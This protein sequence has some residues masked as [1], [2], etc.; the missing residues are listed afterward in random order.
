MTGRTVVAVDLGAESGRV[1]TVSFDG[2]RFELDVVSRFANTPSHRQGLLRWDIDDL[3][4]HIS[5]GIGGLAGN[6]TPIDAIGVDTWGVDY[7]LLNADG[8]L[9]DAPVSYRDGRNIPPFEDAL[10]ALGADRLYGATGVQLM[11]I[12][13]LF[14]LMADARQ[15]PERLAAAKTLLM[16]PDVFHH[17]L[18]GSLVSE[19]T[20]VST[21]GAYDM[22]A[23][24][25]ATE[26]LDELG[27]PTHMLPEVAAPGTDV[28]P[29][30]GDLATGALA[31]ARVV[32]PPGHDTA[33]A[34]VG[35]PLT[36]P[37]GLYIS[38]GTW[39]LAGVETPAPVITELSKAVNLT[40]EG[41]YAGTI[42]LLR[43]VMGLWILQECR[44]QW[45]REGTAYTYPELA[46]LAAR[47]PGLVSVINPDDQVF[48]QPGDMPARIREYCRR[49][50]FPVPATV[51]AVARC[52][53]DS[54]ALSYRVVVD[55]IAAVIG[56]RP[57]S[58]SI[59][60]GGSNH[61]LLSQLTADATGL[62]V[63]CGPVEAT[64][65]GNAAVQLAALGEFD[66]PAEIREAIA[67]GTTMVGYTPAAGD[68]WDE[69]LERF[70]ALRSRPAAPETEP[71]AP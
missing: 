27:V 25:W 2:S 6:G 7:G 37:H 42:R 69:A 15:A 1:T 32:L 34:V 29:L 71:V 70:N 54:L 16:M 40:N 56:V 4:S 44:R 65:L 18:S 53:I 47:E 3:W 28:G 17:R 48:L 46:A 22:A 5:A 20:A 33:S 60:G 39:S 31:G 11:S 50:G 35:A 9:V 23:G 52:V 14:A 41:G 24:R 68:G 66:G 45:E 36:D 13:T 8:E 64:A 12:N 58:V 10:R 62:P 57:P 51:G 26:L 61:E 21:S 43:N 63:R 49:N 59:V 30:V 38:S 55:D 67:A 19:Y